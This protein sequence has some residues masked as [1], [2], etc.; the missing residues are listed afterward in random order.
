MRKKSMKTK[1]I[2]WICIIVLAA[3]ALNYVAFCGI[4]IGKLKYGGMLYEEKLNEAGEVDDDV[5]GGIRKGIDLAGGSVI[6]YQADKEN[7]TDEEMKIAEAIF[8]TRLRGKGYTEARIS[9]DDTGKITVEI[10]AVFETEEAAEILGKVAELTFTDSENNIVLDGASDI[11]DANAKY[12]QVSE[13]GASEHYVELVLT[14]EGQTK[15]AEATRIA[16]AKPTGSN[17]ISINLDG[18]AYSTPMVKEEINSRTS[19]I[20]GIGSAKEAEEL[21]NLIKSG[22]LPFALNKIS[23]DTVGAELGEDALPKSLLAAGIGVILIMLFMIAMYRLPG[24]LADIALTVYIG[25]VALILGLARINLSLSGIAGIVLS[26]GMAVDANCIIFERIKEEMA[27]GKTIKSSVEAG[28]KK[29]FSAIFDSNIT[30][31]ITCVVLYLS[32]IGTVSGFAV[33]LGIGVIVSMFTAIVVTKLL[34]KSVA[35]LGIKN[36]KLICAQKKQGGAQ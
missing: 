22:Q 15:F 32:G 19:V 21:A 13:M 2:A 30:T 23:A 17:Y 10:P 7:P 9:N 20:S 8:E 16:A 4:N 33:T 35:A 5:K 34:L 12:G 25:I 28:F 27:I 31:I 29:A 18:E 36:R 14:A 24:F 3:V 11:E 26:I 1:S 6:T